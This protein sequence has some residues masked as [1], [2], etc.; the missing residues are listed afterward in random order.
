VNRRK[1]TRA[2]ARLHLIAGVAVI[3]LLCN[4]T[5][6]AQTTTTT[7]TKHHHKTVTTTTVVASTSEQQR[8][9]ALSGQMSNLQKQTDDTTS[10]VKK[11]EQAITV[12]PP[13]TADA[14]PATIGE[15]VGLV[16]K[17]V[18]DIK[19]N[20][21]DNLGIS[22]HALVDAG[23]QH[24]FNQPN[25]NVNVYRAWD[26]DGFQLTQGNLHIERDGTVGFVTDI[27][28]GQVAN[29]I[30]AATN[31]SNVPGAH[32]GGQWVDPTQYYLTYTAPIGSGISFE[33]GRFVTL[34]SAEIIP[35]Y[36][37]QNVNESRGLLFTLGEPLGHTGIRASYTFNDYVSATAGLNNGWDDPAANTNGG[38]NY[39]GR[40]TLNNKDK[41]LSLVVN[42]IWG[43]NA[44]P[45]TSSQ[46][47]NSN[48][49][50]IDPI[51]TWKPSFIPNLT[52]E[53]EYL[54][55]SQEG[56]VINGHSASW[57]GLAQ[58]LVYD[59]TPSLESAT[60]G[61]FFQDK[62]GAR[63]T[64]TGQTVWEITQT[65][66]YKIPEVTGLIAR[67][68]YRHDNSDENVFTNNGL[69]NPVTGTNYHLWRGQD[70]LAANIIYAF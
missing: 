30:S 18:S 54:Y 48:L 56:R 45:A 69:I 7:T 52:L 65:L 2:A 37:N 70:T 25:G 23:Y 14:K 19:K 46:H 51:A 47:S 16:E 60:R 36:N 29:S 44:K 21:S 1:T 67:L 38:P 24:N 63:T 34:L 12:A 9:D 6:W 33:A 10:E 27:N 50:A 55:G 42:G 68:E 26:E 39:E 35:R 11:I 3:G 43:P 59:F 40:L 58:Y 53:T 57:Q 22:V 66:S 41:S 62:D 64:G 5:A 20:L 49:G 8:L 13:A 17:D 4:A 61:E 28:F 31:Y 32:V 15:H